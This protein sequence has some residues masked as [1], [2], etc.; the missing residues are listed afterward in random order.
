MTKT[1]TL[2]YS[3]EAEMGWLGA[4]MLDSLDA[5]LGIAKLKATDFHYKEHKLIFRAIKALDGDCDVHD[6][7]KQLKKEGNLVAAGGIANLTMLCQYCGTLDPM[8][9]LKTIQ[10]KTRLR[11]KRKADAKVGKE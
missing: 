8:P 4:M 1:K 5:E 3:K 9:W 10:A 7:A 6:V 11:L 2:A